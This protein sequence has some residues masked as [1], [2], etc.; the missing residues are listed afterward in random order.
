[1]KV[2]RVLNAKNPHQFPKKFHQAKVDRSSK[3]CFL[4]PKNEF[5]AV[6]KIAQIRASK[7]EFTSFE[8]I[9]GMLAPYLGPLGPLGPPARP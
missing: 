2:F 8:T 9:F 4:T 7:H 3:L 1:M 6:Q 5:L